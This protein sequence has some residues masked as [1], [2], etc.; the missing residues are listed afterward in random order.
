[1]WIRPL[2]V[3]ED[4]QE[5][6]RGQISDNQGPGGFW[7]ISKWAF[8]RTA[9]QEV[10]W[11]SGTPSAPG[12]AS[13]CQS[14]APPSPPSGGGGGGERRR[15][16]DSSEVGEVV[17][18]W[19]RHRNNWTTECRCSGVSRCNQAGDTA[20]LTWRRR[21]RRRWGGKRGRERR[22][23]RRRERR[24]KKNPLCWLMF[25]LCCTLLTL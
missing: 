20:Q 22:T 1:M 14:V 6:V 19:R 15:R 8:G 10:G 25:H 23:G 3:L 12:A 9:D 11:A 18:A 24:T 21:R 16:P 13:N 17:Q 2:F 4:L 5:K 7:E